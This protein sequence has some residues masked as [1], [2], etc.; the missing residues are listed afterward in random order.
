MRASGLTIDTFRIFIEAS[1]FVCRLAPLAIPT[2]IGIAAIRRRFKWLEHFH[3]C[4]QGERQVRGSLV[5]PQHSAA[6]AHMSVIRVAKAR[7]D[8]AVGQSPGPPG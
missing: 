2:H 8:V 5:N 7:I 4:K 6:D 3:A 1:P